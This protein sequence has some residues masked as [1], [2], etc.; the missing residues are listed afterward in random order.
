[1]CL[2]SFETRASVV[3]VCMIRCF[4]EGEGEGG[5][6]DVGD[7]D[8][9]EGDGGEGGGVPPAAELRLWCFEKLSRLEQF[10]VYFSIF[11][12]IFLVF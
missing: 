11:F 6:E 4:E 7:V 8:V 12:L 10:S 1:M 2:A 9:D 5:R 3:E